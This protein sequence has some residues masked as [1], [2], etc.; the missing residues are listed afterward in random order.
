MV[1]VKG[2]IRTSDRVALLSTSSAVTSPQSEETR[3]R[4]CAMADPVDAK[5]VMMTTPKMD[6]RIWSPPNRERF[7]MTA[8]LG[9]MLVEEGLKLAH[10]MRFTRSYRS[11]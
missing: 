2:N 5:V 4:S 3:T 6:L 1:I 11:T 10:G 9:E 7:I 8:S